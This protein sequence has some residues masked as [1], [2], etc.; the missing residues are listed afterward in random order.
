MKRVVLKTNEAFAYQGEAM[1]SGDHFKNGASSKSQTSRKSNFNLLMEKTLNMKKISVLVLIYIGLVSFQN[2]YG[3]VPYLSTK[4]SPYS[5]GMGIIPARDAVMFLDKV[6]KYAELETGLVIKG[7][8]TGIEKKEPMYIGTGKKGET[9]LYWVQFGILGGG[10]EVTDKNLKGNSLNICKD[11]IRRIVRNSRDLD[12]NT[13][14][15]LEIIHDLTSDEIQYAWLDENNNRSEKVLFIPLDH[16][17]KEGTKFPDLTVK[18]FNG[19][20]LSINKLMGKT[21]VINYWHMNCG[22]CIA[23][24]PGLN[25]LVEKYKKNPNIV[26]IAITEG[27]VKDITLKTDLTRFLNE[28]KFNYIQTLANEEVYKLFRNAYK[29]PV[30]IIINSAGDICYYSRSGYSEKYL[31]LEEVLDLMLK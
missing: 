6:D 26:F 28:I 25:K 13:M 22:T 19:E 8:Y 15:V 23:Q 12:N 4:L 10:F 27:V 18:K 30:D 9:S 7:T 17:L 21:V 24:I 11:T 29:D 31:E 20:N 16:P 5:L 14:I 3:Q 1:E 2:S